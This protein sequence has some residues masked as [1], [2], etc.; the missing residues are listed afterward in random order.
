MEMKGKTDFEGGISGALTVSYDV[1][2]AK[3]LDG[4]G[5][6]FGYGVDFG[7][8]LAILGDYTYGTANTEDGR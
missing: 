8:F 7:K 3:D 6:F 5:A 4:V 1:E 2:S